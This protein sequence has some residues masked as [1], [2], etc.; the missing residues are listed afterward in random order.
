MQIKFRSR[1]LPSRHPTE[2]IPCMKT[3]RLFF[4]C[5]L[6]SVTFFVLAPCARAQTPQVAQ[7][8]QKVTF[9]SITAEDLIRLCKGVDADKPSEPSTMCLIYLG[10]FTDGY[11][12]AM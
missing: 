12:I 2:I 10:G 3:L 5:L 11:N 6:F 9:S 8:P 1:L 4:M 7:K